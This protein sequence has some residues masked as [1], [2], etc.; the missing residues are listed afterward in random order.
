M[1]RTEHGP[2]DK[3]TMCLENRFGESSASGRV[4]VEALI[5]EGRTR[6]GGGVAAEWII[7][8]LSTQIGVYFVKCGYFFDKELIVGVMSCEVF[9]NPVK[10]GMQGGD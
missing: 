10:E 3:S 4:Q 6:L 9:S 1:S 2:V 8:S 5:V 7:N